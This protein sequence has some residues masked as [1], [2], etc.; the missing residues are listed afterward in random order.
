MDSVEDIVEKIFY[1]ISIKGDINERILKN[2]IKAEVLKKYHRCEEYYTSEKFKMVCKEYNKSKKGKER[3]KRYIKSE[4]GKKS[5]KKYFNRFKGKYAKYKT[6]AKLRNLKF[7]LTLKEFKELIEQ[8]C[9]YCKD[10]KKIGIDRGDNNK[11]YILSNC[12]PCCAMC[13]KTK[14]NLYTKEEFMIIGRAIEKIKKL[15]GET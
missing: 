2:I 7:N 10:A 8:P 4:K 3:S 14:N 12:V 5:V 1:N 13:N 11:G 9:Y 6:S 15:R